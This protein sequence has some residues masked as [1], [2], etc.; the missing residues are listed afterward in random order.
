MLQ[1]GVRG[2]P[3]WVGAWS[4]LRPKCRQTAGTANAESRGATEGQAAAAGP[5][6]ARDQCRRRTQQ[7]GTGEPAGPGGTEH[8]LRRR[9]NILNVY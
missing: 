8:L 3:P 9:L 2:R 7:G 4:V 1:K 6:R 5:L